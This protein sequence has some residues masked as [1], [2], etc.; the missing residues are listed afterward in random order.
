MFERKIASCFNR[1]IRR[2][3]RNQLIINTIYR[4]PD[5]G[6]TLMLN[7]GQQTEKT[8]MDRS[9]LRDRALGEPRAVQKTPKTVVILL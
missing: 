9:V 6:S 8:V 3:V 1:A 4:D 7:L 5:S 2:V